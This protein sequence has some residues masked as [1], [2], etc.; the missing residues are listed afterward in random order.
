MDDLLTR[1]F[2]KTFENKINEAMMYYKYVFPEDEVINFIN[3]LINMQ[4]ED[5]LIYIK[6][7]KTKIDLT[8]KDIFQFSSLDDS[9][10][11]LTRKLKEI[12]DPGLHHIDIGKLLLDDG[13]E[14]EYGAYLKYGENH[15]KTANEIGLLYK[16]SNSYFLSCWGY[17][18]NLLEKDVQSKFLVRLILRTNLLQHLIKIPDNLIDLRTVCSFLS[19]STYTRRKSNIKSIIGILQNSTDY[20]FTDFCNRIKY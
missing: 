5:I 16:S 8:S 10:Y 6:R 20:D 3:E 14:R 7:N 18:F 2:N 1:F 9:I 11:K 4:I 13:I 19:D 15:S 12:K 17:I